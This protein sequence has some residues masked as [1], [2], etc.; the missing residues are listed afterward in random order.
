MYSALELL[1]YLGVF[2]F[3]ASGALAAGRKGMDIF[4]FVFVALLPAVGGG[5]VRD[6]L[7]DVQPF[8]ISDQLNIWVAFAAAVSV[9]LAGKHFRRTRV[10]VWADAIGLSVFA[11]LGARSAYLLTDSTL[12]AVML[13]VTTA[14][15]GGILR[16][17]VCN[18]LPL[19]LHKEIYASAAVAGAGCYCLLKGFAVPDDMAVVTSIGLCFAIRAIAMLTNLSLP[20]SRLED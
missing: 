16:D 12:V 11:V 13:G 18:E 8:W 3:A 20:V 7:L 15:V 5:T 9:F 10:L 6:L 17:V 19:V 4:G 14:V 2:A 1:G